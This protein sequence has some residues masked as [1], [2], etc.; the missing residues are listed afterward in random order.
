M[1][2]LTLYVFL[3]FSTVSYSNNVQISD[4]SF[5]P[6]EN[7]LTFTIFW[8]N[9]W[10]VSND[11]F[12]AAWVFAKYAPNGSNE[13]LPVTLAD[14]VY[15]APIFQLISYDDLGVMIGRANNGIGSFGPATIELITDDLDGDFQDFRLFATEM[16][17][18][19]SGS[20][21]AGDGVSEGRFYQSGITNEPLYITSED[22]LIRGDGPGEFNQEGSSNQE[23]LSADF[24][25]GYDGIFVMKYK[26]TT[27]QYMDFLNCLS[28]TQQNSR[29]VTDLNQS[30]IVNRYV[31]SHFEFMTGK[32]GIKCDAEPGSGQITF[33]MDFDGDDIP[34]EDNDGAV[35]VASLISVEDLLAYL[36]WSGLRPM[37]E[38]EY[39]KFCRGEN[40]PPIPGEYAWGSD[41]YNSG[42][43]VT[44][45]P[46]SINETSSNTGI[47][48]FI[49]KGGANRAGFTAT[50]NSTRALAGATYYGILDIHN[51]FEFMIGVEA[52]QFTKWSY[53]DGMLD[54]NGDSDVS[55]WTADGKYMSSHYIVNIPSPVSQEKTS[56]LFS[57][58]IS[59][60]G[61]RGVRKINPNFN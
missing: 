32:N 40:I 51:L 1:H 22:A 29:T 46:G 5:D 12:D 10:R 45:N 14:S 17:Y 13:W 11:S 4:V 42:G 20:F 23:D 6:T 39:E 31:M 60:N 19:G 52:T 9:S 16:V 35:I 50:S 28:R 49:Y 8:E 41:V 21:Y 30:P 36:D 15:Q 61:F 26:V 7:K 56:P 54:I 2:K 58:G 37:S 55:D 57:I 25:K 48:P 33:Y 38:L 53:G 59:S 47:I 43:L 24:P 44:I 27:K 34:N 3:F 18:V